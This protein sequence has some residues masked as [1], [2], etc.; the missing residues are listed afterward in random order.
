MAAAVL[1]HRQR[2]TLHA[3]LSCVL[4]HGPPNTCGNMSRTQ[5]LEALRDDGVSCT[6][7]GICHRPHRS[8]E[9]SWAVPHS[10]NQVLHV[11]IGLQIVPGDEGI[12]IGR[13]GSQQQRGH[14]PGHSQGQSLRL[15][16]REQTG[17]S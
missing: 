11:S 6:V 15:I 9:A 7:S 14:S 5:P 2:M 10:L 8:C 12:K 16:H 17:A 1:H 3:Q 13:G 4:C